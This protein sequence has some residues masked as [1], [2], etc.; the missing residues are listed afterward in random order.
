MK[1]Q[2]IW[3]TE[4]LLEKK[5]E[6][7][8][9]M[10]KRNLKMRLR[11]HFHSKNLARACSITRIALSFSILLLIASSFLLSNFITTATGDM[12]ISRTIDSFGQINYSFKVSVDFDKTILNNSLALSVHDVRTTTTPYTPIRLENA[13]AANFKL[14]R[15]FIGNVYHL[16]G[17]SPC[18]Y[19][20]ESTHQGTYDWELL[21]D[22]IEAIR[23]IGAEPLLVLGGR[24]MGNNLPL[25]MSVDPSSG[26]NYFPLHIDDFAKYCADIVYH[27]N[28]EN[29]YGIK[30]WEI[31]NE[32]RDDS[33][34]EFTALYNAVQAQ[35]HNV[36]PSI[37][38]GNDRC[39]I[40]R[41]ADY[42]VD[43]IKGLDFAAFHKYDTGDPNELESVLIERASDL[44]TSWREPQSWF[45]TY[46]P[47]EIKAL[48][49]VPVLCTET[50]LDWNTPDSKHNTVFHSVWYAEELRAFI[51]DGNVSYSVF[52]GLAAALNRYGL[53]N[54]E[55]SN[56]LWHP[57]YVNYL[58]GNNLN[59]GDSIC[60]ASSDNFKKVSV[61]AWKN[62]SQKNILLIGKTPELV[63]VTI[64]LILE[65]GNSIMI[66]KVSSI[67]EYEN[68]LEKEFIQFKQPIR[69]TL[70]GFS[71]ILISF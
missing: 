59:V 51:L 46:S 31:W 60:R 44:T 41:F 9:L 54:D 53:M 39:N 40:K 43:H 21:D 22:W 45:Q 16:F 70:N 25:G 12:E 32:A 57:Y 64:Y 33:Q 50:N 1:N 34:I 27:T 47:S 69:I 19:W 7:G 65:E 66:Q 48:L 61:L 20:N 68:I 49:G 23:E 38:I 35:M 63:N 24:I 30:F 55:S 8:C 6:I 3:L 62:D 14:V 28:V 52:Y 17:I 26:D 10:S 18:T 11:D 2:I 71:V 15:V 4:N 36:D 56:T 5:S 29:G 42:Y 13:R 67:S 37:L 58:I